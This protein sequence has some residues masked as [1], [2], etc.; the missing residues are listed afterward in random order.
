MTTTFDAVTLEVL[1]TRIISI[2]DE[3]AKAIVRT[4][5]STLS[6]EANDF[7]CVLTD[8][9]GGALAQNT[10]S[11]PSFIATLPATVRHFL[12]GLGPDGLEPGDVLITNDPWMGTG[13]KSDVCL[14][15][16]IFRAGRLMA[17]SATTSHMPDIGGRIRA[18]EAREV[19]EEG[20][21]I[22]LAK[23]IHAGRVDATL[24]Q[25]LR[26]NV[27]TPDQT[28]GDIWAQVGANELME[29]RVLNLLD[30]Y[31]LDSLEGL[32]DALFTRCERAMRAA[33]RVVPDGTYRYGMKTDGM[34]EPF[35]F[36]IALTV[37][38]DEV[39]ADYTGTSPQ[40][41]RAIN[42]VLA[43]TYAMTA[44]AIRC[45][46]LPG[47]PNNEGMYRPVKVSAPEGCL[48]N[49]RFPA[50][51]VSRS[52]TGHYVPV[53][54]LG[55]LH[56]AIPERVMAGAGSPLWAVTQSGVRE[57]DGKPYTN[58]LFF[59]GGMGATPLKDGENVLSWPSNIS[60][61]PVEVAERNSPLVFHYKR[62][63]PGSG[64]SGR[65]RGGLGQEML[66]ESESESPIALNFMAERTRIPAPGLAGGEPGGLGDVRING[67][68]IDNRTQHIVRRGDRVLVRTPG[69]GGYG[70]VAARDPALVERDRRLG[71]V[72]P[73]R[74]GSGPP[75][76]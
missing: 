24:V 53:L 67:R 10:G 56:Q 48:L 49:P 29:R 13:H 40:Q 25:L 54:V 44:Y 41:P 14:V 9:G 71:Y 3:A 22:P 57:D 42:C 68:R 16:P 32:A 38:G 30:D 27:R 20:L 8:P 15:K 26:A 69:G 28:V 72:K 6:N 17:F 18:I 61:T 35:V 59:N 76:T 7:A 1:W 31:R 19:F 11:I 21:H 2:V 73:G 70:P 36:E 43:Y 75:E 45:A 5:F 52:N 12:R 55:A 39:L 65:F 64:G 63:G 50:A 33:I 47:L 58:V 74:K 60:S 23:L 51:V 37:D 62:L 46:L 4:S 34:A 66:I